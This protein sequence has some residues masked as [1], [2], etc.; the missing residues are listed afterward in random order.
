MLRLTSASRTWLSQQEDGDIELEPRSGLL[1]RQ[2]LAAMYKGEGRLRRCFQ[3][4][5]S[6]EELNRRSSMV[7]IQTTVTSEKTIV[8]TRWR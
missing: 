8:G 4:R 1:F 5:F 7:R 6:C 2:L 3:Q